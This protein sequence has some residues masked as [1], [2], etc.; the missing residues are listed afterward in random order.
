M[1]QKMECRE[2]TWNSASSVSTSW[3]NDTSDLLSC[4]GPDCPSA[5]VASVL[6]LLAASSEAVTKVS[7]SRTTPVGSKTTFLVG[8]HWIGCKNGVGTGKR[9]LAD[10][11]AHRL[12][13]TRI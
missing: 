4:A 9:G 2:E 13:R 3:A 5:L 10:G 1:K 11:Q 8:E 7:T 12:S 6:E